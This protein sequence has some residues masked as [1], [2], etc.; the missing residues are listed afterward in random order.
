M[1]N[2]KK[3]STN[4][5]KSDIKVFDGKTSLATAILASYI[6]VHSRT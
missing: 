2:I 1:A 3:N 4:F 6:T 5:N